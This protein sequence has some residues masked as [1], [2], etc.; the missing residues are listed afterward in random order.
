MY[1]WE[2][3]RDNQGAFGLRLTTKACGAFIGLKW[4]INFPS[5]GIAQN[6]PSYTILLKT[7]HLTQTLNF[8]WRVRLLGTVRF[9]LRVLQNKNSQIFAITLQL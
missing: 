8:Q 3:A 4:S 1:N 7:R 9:N 5:L 2:P 6:T